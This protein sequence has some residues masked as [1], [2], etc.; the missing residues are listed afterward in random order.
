MKHISIKDIARELGI[1]HSTVS[2]ALNDKYDIKKETREKV[3][4]KAEEMGYH[5]NPMARKLKNNKSYNIGVVIPEFRNAFFAD[6]ISGIQDVLLKNGY[7]VLITQSNE[8]LEIEEKNIKTLYNNMVDGL[9]ISLVAEMHNI[10]Y[11]KSLSK[12]GF[13][14]VQFN[15]VSEDLKTSKVVFDDYTWALFATE[16]LIKQGYKNILH[17][18]A[19]KEITLCK[20]RENGFREALRKHKLICNDDQIIQSGLS[21]EEGKKTMEEVLKKGTHFDA[22]FA[23]TDPVAL[24]AMIVLKKHKIKIPQ[25]VGIVGFSES[26]LSEVIEPTLTSVQQPTFEMGQATANLILQEIETEVRVPQ[27]MTLGGNFK[28]KESSVRI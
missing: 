9:I 2:R 3:L 5:P 6:V 16:H 19:S 1:A 25:E 22:I 10:S 28:I 4:K 15:R 12:K 26:R 11:L 17:F 20:C 27:I 24:G 13:P 21:I 7:Q 23:V 18:T 14:I 8:N